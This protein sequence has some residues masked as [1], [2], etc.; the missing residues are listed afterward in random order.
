MNIY[1]NQYNIQYRC[2]DIAFETLSVESEF[3]NCAWHGARIE[4]ITE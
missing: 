2:V 1:S 3:R 4:T